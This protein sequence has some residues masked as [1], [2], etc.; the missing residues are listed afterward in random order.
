[1]LKRKALVD[2]ALEELLLVADDPIK[3]W[4][5]QELDKM[6]ILKLHVPFA[7]LQLEHR[8]DII[9][10]SNGT[11]ILIMHLLLYLLKVILGS[12]KILLLGGIHLPRLYFELVN[13]ALEGEEELLLCRDV[14]ALELKDC[15]S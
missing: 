2:C 8:L 3:E 9:D 14:G 12:C 11:K 15:W 10:I 5:F 6:L 1:M 13:D 4:Q 7:H